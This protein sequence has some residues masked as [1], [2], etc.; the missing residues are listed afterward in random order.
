MDDTNR[1][2]AKRLTKDSKINAYNDALNY[3]RSEE[4]RSDTKDDGKARLWLA[5]KLDKECDKWLRG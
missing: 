2:H 5:D 1:T 3:L 4:S